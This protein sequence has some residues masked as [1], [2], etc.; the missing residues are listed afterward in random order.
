VRTRFPPRTI[1]PFAPFFSPKLTR[2]IKELILGPRVQEINFD[3]GSI[4][5]HAYHFRDVAKLFA[6][7]LQEKGV[8]AVVNPDFLLSEKAAAIYM[9]EYDAMYFASS[10]ALDEEDGRGDAVHECVHLICDY[11]RRV[12]AIR[13][14]EGAAMLARA[15]YMLT[16]PDEIIVLE[17]RG[18]LTE[19]VWEI[20]YSLRQR[21]LSK[22]VPVVM[23]ASEINAIR[24]EAARFGHDNG[25]YHND[26]IA[27][28]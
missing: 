24:G 22:R 18:E 21:W 20:A 15:W 16:S 9:T 19:K 1:D 17:E 26:G 23:K 28:A 12:T 5:V 10:D 2:G 25:H 13:S 11:R 14:E 27:T 8:H 6:S 4:I 3:F 7:S